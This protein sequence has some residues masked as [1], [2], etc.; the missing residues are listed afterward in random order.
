MHQ[1]YQFNLKGN[2]EKICKSL[3]PKQNILQNS[4]LSEVTIL[5]TIHLLKPYH[6]PNK[7]STLA[8]TFFQSNRYVH[9]AICTYIDIRILPNF[10]NNHLE[11]LNIVQF[12]SR[13]LN[14]KDHAILCN[15][16]YQIKSTN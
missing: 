2:W 13:G 1:V 3:I 6:I 8:K 15:I 7:L 4:K 9:K 5:E 14:P 12:Q 16:L 10:T 11:Q